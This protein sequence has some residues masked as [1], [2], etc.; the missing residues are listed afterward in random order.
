MKKHKRLKRILIACL[1]LLTIYFGVFHIWK[2]KPDYT[3]N[4]F[5]MR[6]MTYNLRYAYSDIEAWEDRRD[7]LVEQ[8]KSY[9]PDSLGIQEGDYPWMSESGGLPEL[10]EDYAFVGV[11]RDDGESSGEYAAIFYLKDKYNLIDSGT[12]WLSETPDTP[13]MGWDAVCYRICTW[14]ILEHKET[15]ERF[16]HMNTHL[17]HE[18][19]EARTKASHLL[20]EK[21]NDFDD[22]VILTGDFN[23]LQDTANYQIIENSSL[24]DSK[25]VA[26]DSMWHGT[27]N[28]FLPLNMKWIKPIDFVFVSEGDFT[29]NKYFVDNTEWVNGKP[30]SDHFPVI[31]D[32]KFN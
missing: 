12:F 6:I 22:P 23:Y 20:V 24:E 30:I 7:A 8:I 16:V 19:D 27:M 17:D 4:E 9:Q 29:V 14:V 1:V 28:W 5:E 13:S 26:N 15:N 31:V 2:T 21:L 25:K 18:G 3:L 32:L 11:G 10:L